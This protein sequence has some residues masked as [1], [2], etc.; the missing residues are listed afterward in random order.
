[1][2][3][4]HGGTCHGETEAGEDLGGGEGFHQE[5]RRGCPEEGTLE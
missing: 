1:M 5:L 4:I 2:G 3:T